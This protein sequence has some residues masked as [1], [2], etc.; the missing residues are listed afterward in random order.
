MCILQV[1]RKRIEKMHLV[2]LRIYD[3]FQAFCKLCKTSVPVHTTVISY[4]R[5]SLFECD[6]IGS[7]VG[8]IKT[9]INLRYGNGKF[10]RTIDSIITLSIRESLPNFPAKI[11]QQNCHAPPKTTYYLLLQWKIL[12]LCSN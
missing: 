9:M 7:K 10:I 5:V 11:I 4:R 12:R 6:V 8:Q 3:N 2:F 1:C